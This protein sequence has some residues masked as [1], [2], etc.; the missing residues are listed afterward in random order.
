MYQHRGRK[1][2]GFQNFFLLFLC[3]YLIFLFCEAVHGNMK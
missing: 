2:V 1:V 3:V